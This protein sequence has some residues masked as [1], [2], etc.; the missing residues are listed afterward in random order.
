MRR[1]DF[2]RVHKASSRDPK[3]SRVFMVVSRQV[4][5]DSNFST[6]VCAP[7]YSSHDGLSTEVEVGIEEGLKHA[8]SIRCDEL[9]SIPK[10]VLTHFVGALLPQRI[11]ELDKA[12]GF[13]LELDN[14]S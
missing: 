12:L 10:S 8:S 4:L 13:A 7:I 1:G 6:V 2:Y 14:A 11:K 3:D 9:M 5:I